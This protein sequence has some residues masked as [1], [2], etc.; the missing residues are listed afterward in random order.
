MCSSGA[1]EEAS[2]ERRTRSSAGW[3]RWQ[4]ATARRNSCGVSVASVRRAASSDGMAGAARVRM[5]CESDPGAA[6]PRRRGELAHA[7]TARKWGGARMN[8]I[9]ARGGDGHAAKVGAWRDSICEMP[10]AGARPLGVDRSRRGASARQV[11][12][13]QPLEPNHTRE[14][15]ANNKSE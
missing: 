15:G 12:L 4:A 14:K 3:S 13:E 10:V 8:A 1:K 2:A 11:A 9:D 7:T 5:A 6:R